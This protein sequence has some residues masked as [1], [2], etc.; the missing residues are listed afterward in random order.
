MV[1]GSF[2]AIEKKITDLLAVVADLRREKELL[3]ADLVRKTD[4][5]RELAARVEELSRER[6]EVRKRVETILA[7][8]ENIEL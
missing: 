1:E 2:A 8:L 4:E 7:R 5:G 3:A 6:A